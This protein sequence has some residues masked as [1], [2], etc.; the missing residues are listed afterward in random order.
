M[1]NLITNYY[2]IVVMIVVI[3]TV[4]KELTMCLNV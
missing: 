1:T 3:A 2:L 4:S